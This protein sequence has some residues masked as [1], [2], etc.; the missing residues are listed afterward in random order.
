MI[1]R[2]KG[3]GLHQQRK[4]ANDPNIHQTDSKTG[5]VRTETQWTAELNKHGKSI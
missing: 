5:H 3:P 2:T 4:D 1:C